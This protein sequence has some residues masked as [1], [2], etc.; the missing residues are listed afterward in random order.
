MFDK[1]TTLI[2]LCFGTMSLVAYL[3]LNPAYPLQAVEGYALVLVLEVW[4][5]LV[6]VAGLVHSINAS[7][8]KMDPH[9]W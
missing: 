1:L 9:H 4:F 7:L 6:F 2:L 5:L 8:R 3:P